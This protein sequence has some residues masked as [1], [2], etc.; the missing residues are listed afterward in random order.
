MGTLSNKREYY[1]KVLTNKD[2]GSEQF[3]HSLLEAWCNNLDTRLQPERFDLGEP[4]RRS[5][6]EEGIQAAVNTWVSNGMP[7]MLKRRKKPKFEVDIEWRRRKGLDPRPFPW[8]CTV[9]LD[10]SAG[11]ELALNLLRFL[12]NH[13]EPVFGYVSTYDDNRDKHFITFKDRVGQTEMYVG[14]DIRNTLPGIYWAT[15]FGHWAVSKIGKKRF[16]VL[17]AENAEPIGGGYLILAYHSCAESGS[18][19]AHEAEDRIK[20]HLGKSHFFNKENVNI[21]SLKLDPETV[22]VIE[23][24]IRELKKNK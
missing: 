19:V 13:F 20:G 18:R 6:A 7:L 10:F 21:E 11:D 4:I 22:A 14:L 24:R 8:S 17:E 23:S 3:V 5:F 12:I 9:W 16:T 15:Y 1:L 2:L